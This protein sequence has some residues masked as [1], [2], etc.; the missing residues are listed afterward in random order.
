MA[1]HPQQHDARQS[2]QQPP[3]IWNRSRTSFR[4]I[5]THTAN[6]IVPIL[7]TQ[8]TKIE[9]NSAHVY[10]IMSRRAEI[11]AK[12]TQGQQVVMRQFGTKCVQHPQSPTSHLP[13]VKSPDAFLPPVWSAFGSSTTIAW[14]CP[15]SRSAIVRT[16]S[17]FSS[18]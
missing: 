1:Q 6:A 4:A 7:G 8:I 13:V 16:G 17:S 14:T 18:W 5:Q 10:G 3:G 9:S 11:C 2:P 12:V 15:A